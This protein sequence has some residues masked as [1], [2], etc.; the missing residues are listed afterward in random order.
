M[1]ENNLPIFQVI[2]PLIGAVLCAIIKERKIAWFIA[3]ISSWAVLGVVVILVLR[4]SAFGSLFYQF[5]GWEPPIGIQYQI[6]SLSAFI[7]LLVS[8]IAVVMITYARES[9]GA[10]IDPDK[11][12]LFY[13]IWLLCFAGLIGMVSTNDIFNIYVF[14]EISSLATY[15][16]IA[17]GK[18]RRALFSAFE[19]LVL[20]TIGATFFLIGIGLLYMMTGTLNITDIAE[21]LGNAGD[22]RPVEAAFAFITL[23]LAL[24]IALFPLHTWLTN[25]YAYAPSFASAFLASTAAKVA[26]YIMIRVLYTVFGYEFS[27]NVMPLGIILLLLSIAGMIIASLIAIWQKDVKRLLAFSSVAQIGYIMLA[28]GLATQEGLTAGILHMANHAL[29]K[30]ALFMSV[31]AVVFYTGSSRLEDFRGAAKQMPFTMAVFV[32]GGL[33]LIGLPF[34]AGFV[35]KW[36]LLSAI[37]QKGWWIVAV[38]VLIT[39]ILALIYIWKVVE[40]AY[41]KPRPAGAVKLEEAPAGMLVPMWLL[42]LANIYFGINTNATL[43]L[44]SDAASML[45]GGK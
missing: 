7:L 5:G 3:A 40:A 41:F 36:M 43:G 1:I 15:T 29:A 13:T 22:M 20:G 21:R 35:S 30:G 14:L 17:M 34:T 39:S 18:T 27:F 26:I 9:V 12:H 6:D 4:V 32:V 44:A 31:G 16:L 37:L 10:E 8:A 45:F 11:Q 28:I 23:G 25:A 33:S 2:I 42:V 19:Y 38:I 24:K